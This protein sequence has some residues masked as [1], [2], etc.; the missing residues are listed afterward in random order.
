MRLKLMMKPDTMSIDPCSLSYFR[1]E[2]GSL[3]FRSLELAWAT[4]Q[5]FSKTELSLVP[6]AYNHN[7]WETEAGGLGV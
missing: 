3:E 6:E 4:G 7:T 1:A 5:L 2:A